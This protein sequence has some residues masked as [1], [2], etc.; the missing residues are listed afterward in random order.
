[1]HEHDY[2]HRDL[3][4]EN[5]V[6]GLDKEENLIYLIDFG[7]SKKYKDAKGEHIL[8]K[9]GKSILGTVR[10]VSIYTHLGIEQSRRDDIESLGYILV[11][12][13]KG[14]LPWQGLKAKTQKERY[15]LIMNKKIENKPELLCHGLP[16]AFCQFFEYAR[17]IQFNE[18]PDY[19]YLK[20]LFHRTLTKIN[21]QNDSIFDWCKITKPVDLYQNHIPKYNMFDI[22]KKLESLVK[23]EEGTTQED[24]N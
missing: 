8:Y 10:Y 23:K 22:I 9:E 13:A 15:K 17:G 14:V 12:L 5:W 24:N 4:P 11:Y 6:I 18:R 20:G 1:M 7:L 19:S 2:I 3:K 16:E 21:Y